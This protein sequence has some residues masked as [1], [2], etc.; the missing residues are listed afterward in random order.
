MT[1]AEREKL[2]RERVSRREFL[3]Y[4]ASSVA[5][6]THGFN[7]SVKPSSVSNPEAATRSLLLIHLSGG[8]D[9]Y[10]T[11]VPY[12]EK[13]YYSL[14][15][16]IALKGDELIKIDKRFAFNAALSEL[17]QLYQ[18]G[19]V[20]VFPNVGCEEN[21][22]KSHMRASRIWETASPDEQWKTRWHQRLAPESCSVS[23][24][25]IEGFDTHA[26]QLKQQF[27][28]LRQL[29]IMIGRLRPQLKDTLVFVYSEFGR[30]LAE[31]VTAG[32]DH[33][34]SGLCLALGAAVKGGIYPH[35][36][37]P[38]ASVSAAID[39]RSLYQA[40]ACNWLK[41]SVDQAY[42]EVNFLT[43]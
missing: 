5:L 2:D 18:E 31:N 12:T 43:T 16:S 23:S 13:K 40:I 30:S 39:F 38:S 32:T 34:S 20:A 19:V 24:I 25:V 42:P 6:L 35:A 3:A 27:N 29:S 37:L 21:L 17:A 41:C 15:P 14:R 36:G 4:S 26:D 10:N 7:T 1:D 11:L 9:G 28:A 22:T 8:N 33:G